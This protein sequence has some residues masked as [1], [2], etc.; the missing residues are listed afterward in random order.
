MIGSNLVN[1]C[2]IGW[3]HVPSNSGN[4]WGFGRRAIRNTIGIGNGTCGSD[5]L[6]AL[7]FANTT[8]KN[9]GSGKSTQ[10]FD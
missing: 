10:S 1:D 6:L 4:G 2:R 5:G 8:V 7:N 3:S 9:L